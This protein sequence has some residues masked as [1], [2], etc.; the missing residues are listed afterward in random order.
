MR[1]Y[2]GDLR[3]FGGSRYPSRVRAGNRA[4]V[5]ELYGE[6]GAVLPRRERTAAEK[7]AH[8]ARRQRTN[9]R[10]RTEFG[11]TLAIEP[12]REFEHVFGGPDPFT[13]ALEF[14]AAELRKELCGE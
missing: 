12:D 14:A 5:S 13:E 3:R 4:R 7:A 1:D 8:K 6:D 10:V 2:S 11:E 9:W